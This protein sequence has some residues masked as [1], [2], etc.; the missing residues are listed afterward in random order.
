MHQV[1]Y[2]SASILDISSG[3]ACLL[4]HRHVLQSPP[5]CRA[6]LRLL[7]HLCKQ[8]TCCS[9]QDRMKACFHRPDFNN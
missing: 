5:P 4:P 7:Y 2:T 6:Q 8:L 1:K 3:S 9:I